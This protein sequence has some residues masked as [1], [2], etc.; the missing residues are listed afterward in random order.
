MDTGTVDAT[1]SEFTGRLF[2]KGNFVPGE[3]SSDLNGHGT[4]VAGIAASN[5]YG[6]AKKARVY[7]VKVLNKFGGSSSLTPYMRGVAQIVSDAKAEAKTSNCPRGFL[8]NISIGLDIDQGLSG[9][10]LIRLQQQG[11]MLNQMTSMLLTN[12]DPPLLTFIAAGNFNHWANLTSPGNTPGACTIGNTDGSDFIYR[13]VTS[14]DLVPNVGASCFGTPIQLFAPGTK[15]L[16]T[17]ARNFA[18]PVIDL[19]P[20]SEGPFANF[21]VGNLLGPVHEL[22]MLTKLLENHYWNLNVSSA[23]CRRCRNHSGSQQYQIHDAKHV[24]VSADNG[25]SGQYSESG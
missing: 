19:N 2:Q 13:G 9:D 24:P 21:T 5:T 12:T 16:S 3:D 10:A 14:P 18:D 23:G 4:H 11:A 17:Y 22:I 8:I 20:P 1:G 25:H 15:I 7:A 6:A